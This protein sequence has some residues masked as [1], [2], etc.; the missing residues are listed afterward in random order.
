VVDHLCEE[1]PIDVGDG[2][3]VVWSLGDYSVS[4]WTYADKFVVASL[5]LTNTSITYQLCIHLHRLLL[6]FF[7]DI[8]LNNK[9]L[10]DHLR[11][12]DDAWGVVGMTKIFHLGHVVSAYVGQYKLEDDMIYS[13]DGIYF[14]LE[15]THR[16]MIMLMI[17]DPLLAWNPGDLYEFE[18]PQ[19]A[20]PLYRRVSRLPT[21]SSTLSRVRITDFLV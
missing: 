19:R 10:E 8:I 1:T 13:R 20:E 17:H 18:A 7:D 16:E 21:C 14:V 9:I 11:H 4:P 15:S 5:G 3:G 12:L 2:V 6:P